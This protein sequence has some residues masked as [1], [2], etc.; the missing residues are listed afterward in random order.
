MRTDPMAAVRAEYLRQ[1]SDTFEHFTRGKWVESPIEALAVGGLLISEYEHPGE[2]A[3]KQH[4][5][6]FTALGLKPAL[7]LHRDRA[8][9]VGVQVEA[10][11]DTGAV[12]FDMVAMVGRAIVVIELDGHDFHERTRQQATRD[13]KRDRSI[14]LRGWQVARFTGSEVHRTPCCV[15]S[16]LTEVDLL[17]HD[18]AFAEWEASRRKGKRT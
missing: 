7:I 14:S 17:E 6:R 3:W 18:R 9:I 12:R 10:T 1:A 15:A 16:H 11:L 4:R 2:V 8:Q 5:D 13:K